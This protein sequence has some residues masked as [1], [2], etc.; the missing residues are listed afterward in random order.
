[1][2]NIVESNS[3]GDQIN[4]S[5]LPWLL[6]EEKSNA[7]KEVI[8]KILFPIGFSMNISNLISK[9]SEFGLGLKTYDWHTF[10]KV[11]HNLLYLQYIGETTFIFYCIMLERMD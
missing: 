10:I 1:M 4:A 8:G 2:K 3:D 6:V 7:I 5:S 9:K 11:S